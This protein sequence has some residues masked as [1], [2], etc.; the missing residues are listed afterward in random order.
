MQF[1]DRTS[2]RNSGA[3]GLPEHNRMQSLTTT[4]EQLTS[5]TDC[6]EAILIAFFFS[7][8][9]IPFLALLFSMHGGNLMALRWATNAS[10]LTF[11][12]LICRMARSTLLT[13]GG[14][15]A[16]ETVL[17]DS[18]RL[19]DQILLNRFDNTESM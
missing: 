12:S 10:R 1:N 13:F 15:S 17:H 5:T 16:K 11:A 2:K 3:K 18:A 6:E 19:L 8:A 4:G 7:D 14:M 9:F